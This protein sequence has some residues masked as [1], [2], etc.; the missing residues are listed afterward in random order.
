MPN[1]IFF[2]IKN[3]VNAKKMPD[4]SLW[5]EIALAETL[6]AELITFYYHCN[7]RP[8]P[9]SPNAQTAE[10][11]QFNRSIMIFSRFSTEKGVS[12]NLPR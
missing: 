12:T 4:P 9:E 3:A 5:K 2:K 7:E 11:F 6:T 10:V 8:L 1:A